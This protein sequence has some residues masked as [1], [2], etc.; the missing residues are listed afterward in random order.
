[1]SDESGG[2]SGG[3]WG[4]VIDTVA[5]L[6]GG[7][8]AQGFNQSEAAKSREWQERMYK[9][10]YSMATEDLGRAGLN[11]MLAYTQGVAGATPSGS[12]ASTSDNI[13]AR[14]ADARRGATINSAQIANIEADTE[15]KKAQ[16]D[17]IQGQAAQAWSSAGLNEKNL[18][19]VDASVSRI[20]SEI[21]KINAETANAQETTAV[22]NRTAEKLLQESRLLHERG[23]TE[24]QSRSVMRTTID[25]LVS[26]TSLNQLDID[27]AHVLD[28]MGREA[29]QLKPVIDMIRD[30]IKVGKSGSRR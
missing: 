22:I 6:G 26:E 3:F 13:G 4:S 17:L 12:T 20:K 27:A 18:D 23:L 25:K 10:R 30:A 14:V 24:A 11:P 7:L 19:L 16:A 28:N 21:P 15:N 5:T 8:T 1:M 9:S 29:K 2:S